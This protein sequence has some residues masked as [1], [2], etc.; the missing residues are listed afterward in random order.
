[1]N[2]EKRTIL[3]MVAEGKITEEQAAELLEALGDAGDSEDEAEPVPPKSSSTPPLTDEEY[4]QV[5]SEAYEEVY[6]P[7]YK[8]AYE[9]YGPDSAGLSAEMGNIANQA[10]AA[11]QKAVEDAR[12]KKDAGINAELPPPAVPTPP[13]PPAL[14]APPAP[15]DQEDLERYI[16]QSQEN[17]QRYCREMNE[18]QQE[19]ARIA[20]EYKREMENLRAQ[21]EKRQAPPQSPPQ[22]KTAPSAGGWTGWLAGIG[23]EISQGLREIGRD[24]GR[25]LDDAMEDV[26]EAVSDL[27]DALGDVVEE[28]QEELADEMEEQ[29]EQMEEAAELAEE[30]PFLTFDHGL[31]DEGEGVSSGSGPEYENGEFVYRKW[32]G[33]SALE[34]LDVNWLTGQVTI[35]PWDGDHIEVVEYSKKALNREQ[36]C[37]MFVQ[38]AKRLTIR[39]YAQKNGPGGIFGKGWSPFG[40]PSK[41]LEVL[42]PRDQCEGI[43]KLRVQCMSSTVRVSELSGESF[44]ISAVSGTALLRSISAETLDAGT[45]SGTLT[46]ENCSA[47]KLHAHSVSGTNLCKGFSAEKA[48]L[49]TVSGTLNAQGNAEK[50]KINTVSG[51]A[52]LTVDQCPEK[53]NMSSVSGSLKLRL[54]ENAGFTADYSSTS[55]SFSTDFDAEIKADGKRKKSGRAVFGNGE[56]KIGLHTTS[57]SMKILKSDGTS[58]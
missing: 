57:G 22:P 30:N 58:V 6:E 16:R 13:A 3:E 23:E 27:Q 11:A 48:E 50:F 42:I 31:D 51:S 1:M 2:E 9:K 45:V 47:E 24:L 44:E 20:A 10:E 40:W 14:P 36:Q 18:Y 35:A 7:A 33:L 17:N 43:E 46:L 38:D 37:V 25:D 21:A 56:T 39:E 54:P 32:A 19:M 15:G 8:A 52:S 26:A 53:A 55:G 12:A 4:S 28:W 5:Y 49:T 34:N 41:R 29:A